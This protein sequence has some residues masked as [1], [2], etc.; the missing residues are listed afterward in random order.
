M[1]IPTVRVYI[2]YYLSLT[3]PDAMHTYSSNYS[4]RAC[5]VL[6]YSFV[7]SDVIVSVSQHPFTR[8]WKHIKLSKR[9][10]GFGT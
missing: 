7:Y 8:G 9:S 1:C 2:L 5:Y 3:N 6:V 10:V 4:D